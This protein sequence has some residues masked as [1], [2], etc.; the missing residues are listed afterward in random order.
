MS[1][2][3][4]LFPRYAFKTWTG[5]VL[6]DGPYLFLRAGIMSCVEVALRGQARYGKAA[7]LK[8]SVSLHEDYY[9]YYYFFCRGSK[10]FVSFSVRAARS[11]VFPVQVFRALPSPPRPGQP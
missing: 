7:F 11:C 8:L 3:I 2:V 9:Y 4:P 10:G 5:I 1:E 6:L